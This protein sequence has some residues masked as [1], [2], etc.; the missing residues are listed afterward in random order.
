MSDETVHSFKYLAREYKLKRD[1]IRPYLVCGTLGAE[2]LNKKSL[3]DFEASRD[4]IKEYLS[5]V[6]HQAILMTSSD[7]EVRKVAQSLIK[8]FNL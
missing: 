6:E 4:L 3:E 8:E 7:P 1:L 5:K 2:L